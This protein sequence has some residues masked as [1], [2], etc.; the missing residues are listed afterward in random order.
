MHSY[1]KMKDPKRQAKLDA[2]DRLL[3]IMDELREQC[4]WDQK[5]T[6]QS[7]RHLTIEETYELADAITNNDLQ[8]VKKEI[9]DILLHLVFYARIASETN[10]FDIEDVINSLCEKMIRRHPHIY[11]DV[12]AETSEQVKQNW[13]QIKLKE[14][15]GKAEKTVLGGVPNSMPA[16]VK[17]YR[18][19]EK[20]AAVGFDWDKKED[21]WEK[22]LEEL[23]EFKDET[24]ATDVKKEKVEGE[25][26]DLIFA[27]INYARFEGINAEDALDRT[28]KKFVT[29]FN[30]LEAQAKK[31]GKQ[32][33]DM[34]LAEMDVYWNEAKKLA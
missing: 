23:K 6:I 24:E 15:D 27:L 18:I 25:F 4:P 11:G 26:G 7:L 16:L 2:F 10:E 20:A 5:Q 19:Q 31:S 9:G 12:K 1:T 8:E 33:A 14:K 13:E 22:V 21:V 30:Y 28:N 29:R 17:A 3:T 34:T 32:L